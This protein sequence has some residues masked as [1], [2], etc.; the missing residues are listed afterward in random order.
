MAGRLLL[1]Q[2]LRER[3]AAAGL[4]VSDSEQARLVA[5]L[6][7]LYRWNQK[8][9]LTAFDLSSPTAEAI[10]RL[11]IEPLV[12]GALVRGCD[13]VALDVGSGGGSPGIPLAIRCP[14]IQMTLV[15]SRQRKA[16]F[17]REAV[18][19]L[20]L[21]ASVAACRLDDVVEGARGSVDVLSIR[22]VRLDDGVAAGVVELLAPAGRALLFGHK[23][24]NVIGMVVDESACPVGS[25][26][27][28]VAR[29]DLS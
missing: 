21:R 1:E 26:R 23:A 20:G 7:L 18:R 11:A 19:V 29:K 8:M 5:Y 2:S 3:V 24:E 28:S 22:G 27:I 6:E 16:S 10:D 12:A 25:F 14:W 15:E 17:L 13:R 4:T 9:N